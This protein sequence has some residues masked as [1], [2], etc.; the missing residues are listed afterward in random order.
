MAAAGDLALHGY[1]AF[2]G[3]NGNDVHAD[4]V[5]ASTSDVGEVMRRKL[6][7]VLQPKGTLPYVVSCPPS[8]TITG[9]VTMRIKTSTNTYA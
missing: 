2:V 1:A 8:L 6:P 9:S 3:H 7:P 5:A 4:D